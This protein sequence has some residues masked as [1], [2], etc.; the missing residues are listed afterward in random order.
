[1][2]VVLSGVEVAAKLEEQFPASVVESNRSSLV[3]KSQSLAKIISFLKTT[4]EFDFD[5]LNN[6]TSTDYF[7][8]FEVVYNLTSFKHNHSLMIKTRSY[9]RQ[10]PV[11]PSLVS[12][13]QGADF[14]EREVYDLMGIEFEGHP[15][16]KRILLWDGF[17]GHPLRKDYL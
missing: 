10:K 6:V 16:M 5:F 12:L 4:S 3:V 2:T 11:V 7:D 8:Y 15:N 17:Q 14:Q 1:M 13:Y 9:D